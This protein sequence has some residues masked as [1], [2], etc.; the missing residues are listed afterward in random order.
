MRYIHEE[1]GVRTNNNYF[2]NDIEDGKRICV[3]GKIIIYRG[4]PE[5]IV[6]DPSQIKVK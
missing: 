5:I 1:G 2:W 3:T 6:E 4:I